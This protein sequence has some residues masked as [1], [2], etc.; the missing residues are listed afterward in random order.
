M[1]NL[2]EE[3]ILPR[4]TK[5][6]RYQG[7]EFNSVHKDWDAVKVRMAF[8]FPDVYEVGMSHLGLQ[9]LYGIVNGQEDYLL[10]RVFAPWTDMEDLLR[11]HNL[12]LFSLESYR[13]VKEFDLLG[14]TLQY[15]M[16]FTNILNM[17]D[18]AGI[19]PRAA[20]RED[21]FPLIIGGGPC[22]F[23][24]EP[25]ADFF[26]FFVIGDAEEAILEILDLARA[27][28]SKGGA[29]IPKAAF[30]AAVGKLPGIYVPSFYEVSYNQHGGIQEI[31]PR[32]PG[33]QE[34][35]V[36]RVVPDLN[37]AFFPLK[38]IVPFADTVHNR[39]MLE[40]LRGCTRSCRF[41]QAGVIYRPVR[42]R[43]QELLLKQA[44]ELVRNT[45]HDEISLTSLSTA[46]YTC[47]QPLIANLMQHF[48]DDNV[49]IS[50]PSL[51]ADAFSVAL[52][53][54]IQ[55]VRK[56][57]LTF[58][59]EAGTQRLR[60]V[61]NK[62]VTAEDLMSAISGAFQAGWSSIKLYFMIGLPTETEEDL[63]GI[64][65]LAYKVLNRGKGILKELKSRQ[66]PKVTVSVSSFVPKA[67]TPFQWCAQDSILA[68]Q[69]KQQYLKGLFKD[70]RIIYNYHDARLSFLEA[71][72]AKGDRRLGQ[73]LQLAWAKGCKFDSWSEMFKYDK[74]REAF[75]ECGLDP[76]FY[77][78]RRLAFSEILPWD[79]LHSGVS[80]KYLQHEY[81]KAM[82]AELTGDCRLERCSGC[83]VC[84]D[85]NVKLLLQKK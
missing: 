37:T 12:P 61:I 52:A 69:E 33:Q 60:D 35:V 29:K 14:F 56:T 15:E 1:R 83:G 18:L 21:S 41:C 53:R 68:L 28:K 74:W 2:I 17:L 77:A 62:G 39:V 79:H 65:E 30:L 72:F 43:E 45:G 25:L 40:V 80:K 73:A 7:E 57:G 75:A 26:D 76:D 23:N 47:V 85:L 9:I 51:R 50:L 55:K 20:E 5:P 67:H 36:K 54:E 63:A 70:R 71:V 46:D 32:Q 31:K 82:Q 11:Q 42:E 81:E 10:E 84:G 58:A 8:A 16:S 34:R 44:K 19:P 22:A 24:P 38:P 3:Q 59:P 27:L 66:S 78:Y 4:V 49:G 6:I 48:Q 13:P 64:A